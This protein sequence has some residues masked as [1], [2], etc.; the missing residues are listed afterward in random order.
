MNYA[1]MGYE[2]V[3]EGVKQY[4]PA[5]GGEAMMKF[6]KRHAD[7]AL[8]SGIYVTFSNPEK[9]DHE[10]GRVGSRSKCMCGHLYS[11]HKLTCTKKKLA[12]PCQS[13]ACKIFENIPQRPEECG[14]YW[15][16]RRKEFKLAD[17]RAPCKCRHGHDSHNPNYP[18]GCKKCGCSSFHSD[19]ACI[20]CDGK[21]EDH[22]TL[23]EFEHDRVMAKKKVGQD[24]QPLGAGTE[25]HNLMFDPK[26]RKELPNFNRPAPKKNMI[27]S[28]PMTGP[29]SFNPL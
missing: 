7:E 14:M 9:N 25:L 17:W 15:L 3:L 16:P 28:K 4:G 2:A 8:E 5:A 27:T 12:N 11:S 24:F 6:E 18:R 26:L 20:S 13:C 22:I 29:V 21:W 1:H 10:C 23:Y 19:F